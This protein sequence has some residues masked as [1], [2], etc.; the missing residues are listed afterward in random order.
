MSEADTRHLAMLAEAAPIAI[1]VADAGGTLRSANGQ[2][3]A[4]FGYE[5]EELVGQPLE[6][7]IPVRF[8]K[9]HPALR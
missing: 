6:L 5:R 7:L 9:G 4:L 1:V 8:R 2:A 3:L